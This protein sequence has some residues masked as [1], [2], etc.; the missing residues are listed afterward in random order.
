MWPGG[1]AG[2]VS[3]RAAARALGVLFLTGVLYLRNQLY[4]PLRGIRMGK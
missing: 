3:N 1:E 2:H 4:T